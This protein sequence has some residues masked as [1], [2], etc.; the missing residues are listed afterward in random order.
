[1]QSYATASQ[2][3][4]GFQGFQGPAGPTGLGPA[5]LV[6]DVFNNIVQV[7]QG[8][9]GFQGNQGAQ[10]P[11]G[12]NPVYPWVVPVNVYLDAI[13]DVNWNR[14][15]IAGAT[16]PNTGG[17]NTEP[18]MFNNGYLTTLG[19]QNSEITF[20]LLIP[21]GTWTAK[22][23]SYR[24]SDAGIITFSFDGVSV[25]TIDQYNSSDSKNAL[26]T[27]AGIVVAATSVKTVNLK[28]ATKNGSSSNYTGRIAG[29]SFVRTS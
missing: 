9:Q 24:S 29:L 13:S 12:A 27:I 8:I 28:M 10:G 15:Y 23:V 11:Q 22:I 18:N 5:I 20:M 4:Q 17:T 1:M 6:R 3:P 25:G 26:Q 16:A 21:A 7:N 2:G 14:W 19:A